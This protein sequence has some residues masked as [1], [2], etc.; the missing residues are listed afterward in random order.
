MVL[1]GSNSYNQKYYLDKQ[2]EKLPKGVKDE[3]K[4]L[5]VLFTEEVGGTI[6]FS[7]DE[8]GKLVIETACDEGD[9]LYDSIGAGLLVKKLQNDR[10]E[11]FE[12][13]ELYYRVFILGES[14]D[15]E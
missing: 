11:F 1:C 8:D 6:T 3:L 15:D 7:Y 2:F 10:Q 9:L 12:A 5:C 13:L 4:I 14:V